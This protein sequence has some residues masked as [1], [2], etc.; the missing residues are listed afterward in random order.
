MKFVKE[1]VPARINMWVERVDN[2]MMD[3]EIS[4]KLISLYE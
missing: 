1:N 4:G 2:V 3:L